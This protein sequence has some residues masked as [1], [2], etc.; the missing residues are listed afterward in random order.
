MHAD[1]KANADAFTNGG[2]FAAADANAKAFGNGGFAAANA[3][4]KAF[5]NGGGF[6]AADA[7]AK[8][9]TNG[10]GFAA[11]DAKATAGSIGGRG[12]SF[13]SEYGCHFT[14]TTRLVVRHALYGVLRWCSF[15]CC[16]G[17][18]VSPTTTPQQHRAPKA[19]AWRVQSLTS[20][21]H[22]V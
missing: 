8:A 1:A 10:G 3:D 12:G 16:G 14:G 9:F 22:C 6:A 13:A 18:A 7:D 21:L 15:L 17:C 20:Q 5:T 19:C 11:A 2:G 4:A